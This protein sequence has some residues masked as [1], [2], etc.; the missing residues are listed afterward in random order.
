VVKLDPAD[1][2]VAL[3]QAEAQ[4]AQTVREVRTVYANNNTLQS[5]ISARAADV[6]R[7]EADLAKAQDDVARR[8]PLVQ[9]GAVGKE[10]FAHATAQLNAA[11]SAVA[12]AQS[13]RRAAEEQLAS[14]Q[15]Q[16]E[17][18]PV[19][20]HP[21]VQRAAA[22]VHEA[23]LSLQR[24]ELRAPVDGFVAKRSVQL[25]QRVQAG[26][27][28]M[29]IVAL[30]QVWVEANFKESQLKNLRIG[31]PAELVAD[32]YGKKVVYHG[33]IE[34]LGAGTGSAFSLLPAQNATG[35][36]IKVV[37]RVPVRIAL[38]GNELAQ[39]PLRVGL[40]MEATVDIHDTNG[41]MLADGGRSTP[42]AMIATPDHAREE[43]DAEVHRIIVANSGRGGAPSLARNGSP[44]MARSGV[45]TFSASA[46]QSRSRNAQ[47]PARNGASPATTAQGSK[48]AASNEQEPAAAHD[49]RT[50]LAER[51]AGAS[52]VVK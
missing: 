49:A 5:Q 6:A 30:S 1:A 14:N 22:Q 10:E 36:W 52:S 27:P 29:S 18:T 11:R 46:A 37:Q 7:A 24:A 31:Q 8:A 39:H 20:Q 26:A 3:N 25:G 35:N 12:A 32:V 28:L 17:G 34:G 4:L 43:A 50:F 23:Y 33:T 15:T 2:Q 9:S 13:A 38:D 48:V 51:R 41:R 19:D 16:T 42:V 47:V 45:T 44:P 40:S 21:S